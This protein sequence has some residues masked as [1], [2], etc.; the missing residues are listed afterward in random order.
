MKRAFTS[1][2]T[3]ALIKITEICSWLL[4]CAEHRTFFFF[5]ILLC[6]LSVSSTRQHGNPHRWPWEERAGAHEPGWHG[7]AGL[8]KVTHKWSATSNK[9]VLIQAS[10]ISASADSK[11]QWLLRT[12]TLNPHV[13]C[14]YF[15][16]NA[17]WVEL[18]HSVGLFSVPHAVRP[19]EMKCKQILFFRA[20]FPHLKHSTNQTNFFYL[21]QIFLRLFSPHGAPTVILCAS[22]VFTWRAIEQ[23]LLWDC[24]PVVVALQCLQWQSIKHAMLL[25]R[26]IKN[27]VLK[28]KDLKWQSNHF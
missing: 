5:R 8:P 21:I 24:S 7:G 15:V 25:I 11:F 10:T 14:D 18:K 12:F 13:L 3:S 1:N 19:V 28:V 27:C 26:F 20:D 22:K 2:L 23:G 16:V 6:F 9:A 17:S 4:W